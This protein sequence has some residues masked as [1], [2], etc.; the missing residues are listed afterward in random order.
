VDDAKVAQCVVI[1]LHPS[2]DPA[3]D[4]IALAKP[5]EVARRA[6]SLAGGVEPKGQKDFRIDGGATGSGTASLDL[7]VEAT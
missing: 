3:I 4:V 2:A 7:V 1:G 5:G 6:D